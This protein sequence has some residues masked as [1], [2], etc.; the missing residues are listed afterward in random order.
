MKVT[1]PPNATTPPHTHAG[2]FVAVHVLSGAVLNKMNDDPMTINKAGDNF[3]EAPGCRHRISDNA[4]AAEEASL[5][6]V[7]VLETE[8]IEAIIEKEGVEGLVVIDE[9]YKEAVMAQM[10]KMQAKA[11]R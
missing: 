11:G 4:S 8:V 5:L 2:A 6:V 10:M 9:E 3:Y 7:F 1:F